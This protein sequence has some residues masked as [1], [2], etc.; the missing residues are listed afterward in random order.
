MIFVI[1]FIYVGD[2][3]RALVAGVDGQLG[4]D[5]VNELKSVD[6]LQLV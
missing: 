1:F 4:H 2:R 3:V 6:I 5:I